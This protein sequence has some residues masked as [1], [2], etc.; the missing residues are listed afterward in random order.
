[1]LAKI[2]SSGSVDHG[3]EYAA[4]AWGGPPYTGVTHFRAYR[5]IPLPPSPQG[6]EGG[7]GIKGILGGEAAQNTLL[8]G[9]PRPQSGAGARGWGHSV[10]QL[11]NSYIF[12]TMLRG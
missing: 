7:I 12:E 2:C 6:G 3:Y 4:K 8:K 11:R 5:S 9:F 10:V 1:M